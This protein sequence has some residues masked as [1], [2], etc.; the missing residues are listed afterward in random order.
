MTDAAHSTTTTD[1]R[2]D[3]WNAYY[4]ERST[5]RRPLPSQFATFVAGELEGPHR[6][7]ELGCGNGRDSIFFAGHG[8]DVTGVDGSD[9]AVASSTALAGALGEPATFL[10]STIDDPALPERLAGSPGPHLVYARFFVHAITDAEEQTF[11]DL[12]AAITSPGDGLAVEYRTVRDRVGAKETGA[13][14]RRFVLPASFQ[15]RAQERGFEVTYA[16]EGFGFAKWRHDDAYVART[17][18]RRT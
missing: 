17:L 14:Y 6:V 9:A 8:H 16:V 15:A 3:Y 2:S 4:A 12:A 11:L 1:D 18:F 7:I 13:H 5:T 10:Q